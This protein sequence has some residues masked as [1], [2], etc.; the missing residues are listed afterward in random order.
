M[1]IYDFI[2]QSITEAQVSTIIAKAGYNPL[3]YKYSPR[4]DHDGYVAQGEVAMSLTL[5]RNAAKTLKIKVE[6]VSAIASLK[7]GAGR[8]SLADDATD[9]QVTISM[10]A[11]TVQALL[12]GN[13]YLYGFKAVQA[14]QGG[15]APLVWFQTQTFSTQTI[16]LWQEQYQAYTSTNQVIPNGQ[17]L[18]SFSTD[19]DLG[20]TLQVQSGGVG[21]VIDG[22]PDTAISILNTTSMQFT[23]GIAETVSGSANPLCAFPLYGNNMDVIAPIE[24][25]L[26]MFSTLPVNTGTVVMQAYSSSILIDLTADNQRSVTYDINAG[27]SWGGYSWAQQIPPNSQLVPLLIEPASASAKKR[28]LVA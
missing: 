27:W 17:I 24:K 8:Q 7:E 28:L 13:F 25:V 2:S 4:V 10:S 5:L 11:A 21:P 16:V 1:Q 20:Q 12:A 14:T 22:G 3:D 9:Y 18:A 23:C 6:I 19:I 15:G 26:L